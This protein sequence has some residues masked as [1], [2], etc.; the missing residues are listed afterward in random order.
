MT[1][2][3]SVNSVT[4]RLSHHSSFLSPDQLTKL[5]RVLPLIGL[6]I[7]DVYVALLKRPQCCT[8][9]VVRPSVR[10]CVF[11]SRS[12]GFCFFLFEIRK[13]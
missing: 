13:P 9:S 5:G 6:E 12:S 8:Q 7:G 1:V 2:R 10:L 11:P 3:P 4:V